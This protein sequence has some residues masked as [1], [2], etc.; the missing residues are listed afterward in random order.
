MLDVP[1]VFWVSTASVSSRRICTPTTACWHPV[2]LTTAHLY[3]VGMAAANVASVYAAVAI[4][5]SFAAVKTEIVNIIKARN[6]MVSADKLQQ[7]GETTLLQA[8]T[9]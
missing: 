2:P 6:V 9:D 1:K 8:P 5:E 4:M 7:K 3:A